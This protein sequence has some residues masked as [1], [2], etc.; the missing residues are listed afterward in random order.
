LFVSV[1]KILMRGFVADAFNEQ[2]IAI[3]FAG[4]EIVSGVGY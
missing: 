2:W 1:L 4:R 3:F